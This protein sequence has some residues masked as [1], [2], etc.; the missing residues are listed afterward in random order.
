MLFGGGVHGLYQIAGKEL[1]P[2]KNIINQRLHTKTD[3]FSYKVGQILVTFALT[4]FAWIFFRAGTLSQ[5]LEIIK[6]IFCDINLWT[7]FDG[8]LYNLGLDMKEVHILFVSILALFMV[9]L[10]KYRSDLRLD[11]FLEKQCIWFRW[12]IIICILFSCIIFGKYGPGFNSGQFIY[13]QF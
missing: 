11:F 2:I 10:V 1:A 12:T 6:R 5:A 7:L 9:D 3:S 13:F 8:S 4:N